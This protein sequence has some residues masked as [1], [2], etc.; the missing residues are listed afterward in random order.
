MSNS[1]DKKL[2]RY[3]KTIPSMYKPS[4]NTFVNALLKAWSVSDAK[5][6]DSVQEAK[7]AIFVSDSEG[8]YL[9]SLGDNVGV[10]RPSGIN[11]DEAKYRELIPI[12]S[13]HPKH[14][15]ELII[16][17]LVENQEKFK[18][19]NNPNYYNIEILKKIKSIK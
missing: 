4:T 17:D 5:V 9:D 10:S 6:V 13:F 15:V 8:K 12:L 3:Y 1:K 16:Q 18:D 11:L 7:N 19:F 2:E 14:D